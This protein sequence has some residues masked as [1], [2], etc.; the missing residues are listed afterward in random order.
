MFEQTHTIQPPSVAVAKDNAP[1]FVDFRGLRTLFAIP[2]STAYELIAAGEIR[3]VSLRR[4]GNIRG[5]RLI[6][7]ASVRAYFNRHAT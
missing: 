6:D 7:C 5:R 1:E 2:R 4:K 3:A